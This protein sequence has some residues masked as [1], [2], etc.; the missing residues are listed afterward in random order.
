VLGHLADYGI[1][2]AV[3]SLGYRPDAFINAYPDGTVAGISDLLRGGAPPPLDTAGR[4]PVS[5][6]I[7]PAID[8]TLRGGQR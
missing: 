7:T 2:D 1:D 6:P 4:H 5:P 8:E 3:L